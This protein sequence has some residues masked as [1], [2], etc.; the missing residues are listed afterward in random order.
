MYTT[1][2]FVLRLG[3]VPRLPRVWAPSRGEGEAASSDGVLKLASVA[4]RTDGTE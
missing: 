1:E 4:Y 2:A 3:V